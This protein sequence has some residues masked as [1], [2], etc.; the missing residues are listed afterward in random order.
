MVFKAVIEQFN[1][2][3]VG[4]DNFCHAATIHQAGGLRCSG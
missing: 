4:L 2:V 3:L 1:A